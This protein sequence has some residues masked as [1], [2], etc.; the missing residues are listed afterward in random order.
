MAT[1]NRGVAVEAAEDVVVDGFQDQ[2]DK[3]EEPVIEQLGL[4]DRIG[5]NSAAVDMTWMRRYFMMRE[6]VGERDMSHARRL[7]KARMY[8]RKFADAIRIE[9]TDIEDN[10]L[11]NINV[12]GQ[13]EGMRQ[14]YEDR[15][16]F[17]LNDFFQNA[18]NENYLMGSFTGSE[19]ETIYVGS[20]DGE[21]LLSDSHPY[22]EQI[23]YDPQAR[24]G[25]RVK[26]TQGGTFSNLVND[27][28]TEDNLWKART[29]Y[30]QL[31][32]FRGK[33][34]NAGIPDTLVVGPKQIRKARQLLERSTKLEEG[35]NGAAPVENE[36]QGMFRVVEN[37]WL[38]G[39]VQGVDMTFNGSTIT[40]QEIDL[41]K[42]WFLANT[43]S[44]RKPFVFMDR[45]PL[46][47]QRPIGSPG[48]QSDNP[49]EG[50]VDYATFKDDAMV[51]GVRAR[52]GVSFGSPHMIYGSLGDITL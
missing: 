49:A 3:I 2:L 48:L 41:D 5:A 4:V 46:Q 32:N 34:A 19:G 50:A 45:T 8:S 39:K 13:L 20:V 33:P 37:P 29:N 42:A 7:F 9:I 28:L 36:T 15:I 10:N 40:D 44:N 47:L 25:Q 43:T 12:D 30:M 18:M 1:I 24:P 35:T 14:G 38:S 23:E 27:A 51:F 52:F 17:E 6:W 31:K 21:P 11:A 22:Y 16:E 26:L